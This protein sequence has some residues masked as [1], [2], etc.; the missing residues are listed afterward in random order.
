[1]SHPHIP[2]K[3]AAALEHAHLLGMVHRDVKPDNIIVSHDGENAMLVDF[4]IALT[5]PSDNEGVQNG[6]A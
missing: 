6:H 1:M 5:G 4:G 3:V 2:A